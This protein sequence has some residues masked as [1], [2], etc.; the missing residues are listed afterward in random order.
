VSTASIRATISA[1]RRG[2][3]REV[4]PVPNE[5]SDHD[6]RDRADSRHGPPGTLGHL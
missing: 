6:N 5:K 1:I 2:L 4:E 3:H